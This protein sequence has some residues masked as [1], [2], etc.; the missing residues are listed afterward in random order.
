MMMNYN[1]SKQLDYGKEFCTNLSKFNALGNNMVKTMINN[2]QNNNLE[3]LNGLNNQSQLSPIT[4]QN[5]HLSHDQN[6]LI[7]NHVNTNGLHNDL[8]HTNDLNPSNSSSINSN[9]LL[10][11]N[12]NSASSIQIN[13]S[14]N[15][16][17]TNSSNSSSS[18]NKQKRHRTRFTPNQLQQLEVSSFFSISNI[19]IHFIC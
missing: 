2:H 14:T 5:H 4:H 17:S 18:A 8:H 6:L 3:L 10:I 16:S 12:T 13:N 19:I 11:N 15:S 7:Q 9:T 1:C